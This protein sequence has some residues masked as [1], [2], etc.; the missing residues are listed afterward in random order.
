MRILVVAGDAD[1]R[2]RAHVDELAIAHEVA[3]VSTR[4]FDAPEGVRV[5]RFE[6]ASALLDRL[7]A[8]AR[9]Y[10]AVLFYGSEHEACAL[11]VRVVPERAALVP[12]VRDP[13]AL[14]EPSAQALFHLPRV[15]GFTSPA[16]EE[17]VRSRFRNGHIPGEQLGE[18][19]ALER[20]LALATA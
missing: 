3:V 19:G 20:M 11:G 10:D 6:R 15:F 7:H 17:L 2:T 4:E 1:P 8:S 13:S 18:E 5:E 9:G 16:E 12:L 14:G